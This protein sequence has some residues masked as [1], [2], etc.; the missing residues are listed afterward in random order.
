MT[1]SYGFYHPASTQATNVY[2]FR[3][4]VAVSGTARWNL[5]MSGTAPNY[6]NSNLV[7]GGTAF[8]ST[9]VAVLT[10]TNSTAP[11]AGVANTVAFYSSD[12]AAGHTVPSFYCEGTNV[13]AT[14]Q[15]DTTSSVRVK[16]RIQG[17]VYTFLCI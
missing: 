11:A 5:Y 16:M 8:D 3:G 14:G 4:E 7:I 1:N 13:V 10:M 12:D 17:T 9:G 2:A 15:A 6:L